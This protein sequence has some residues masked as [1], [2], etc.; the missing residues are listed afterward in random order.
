VD[1]SPSSGA[2]QD[3][4]QRLNYE[5]L[6]AE[7]RRGSLYDNLHRISEQFYGALRYTKR[8]NPNQLDRYRQRRRD[9]L[10]IAGYVA[11]GMAVLAAAI[12]LA[13][14]LTHG[15]MGWLSGLAVIL[16]VIAPLAALALFSSLCNGSDLPY[17]SDSRRT[18]TTSG[19]RYTLNCTSASEAC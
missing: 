13:I 12:G 18:D 10:I 4:K 1:I 7:A 2:K 14:L 16:Y 3:G 11:V 15:G 5:K 9:W 8:M 6:R 17:T 19:S